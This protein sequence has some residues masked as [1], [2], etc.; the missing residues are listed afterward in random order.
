MRWRLF[1]GLLVLAPRVAHGGAHETPRYSLENG[2]IVI[3]HDGLREELAADCGSAVGLEVREDRLVVSCRAS[4]A[5]YSLSDPLHP[6]LEGRIAARFV[7]ARFASMA[8]PSAIES[9][10]CSLSPVGT[11]GG[12][13]RPFD[14]RVDGRRCSSIP[15]RDG[16]LTLSVRIDDSEIFSEIWSSIILEAEAPSDAAIEEVRAVLGDIGREL[17]RRIA[18]ASA[19]EPTEAPPAKPKH[20]WYGW[21][22]IIVDGAALGSCATVVLIPAGI[23]LYG[24]GPPI[25][26]WI[27]GY[28]TRGLASMAFRLAPPL[29]GMGLGALFGGIAAAAQT[30]RFGNC[31][32]GEMP[33]NGAGIGV[34]SGTITAAIIAPIIDSFMAYDDPPKS[35]RVLPS[36]APTKD[37]ATIGLSGTF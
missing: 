10:A 9:I 35:V 27:H 2:K 8:K 23:L 15:P 12:R 6:V 20:E 16:S 11:I 24:F 4:T 19:A 22:T 31:G 28:K 26:H 32:R 18:S 34:V 3:E 5:I 7:R 33:I 25:V 1:A 36:V 29:V 17:K 13:V 37:G 21:Q 14:V 30:C